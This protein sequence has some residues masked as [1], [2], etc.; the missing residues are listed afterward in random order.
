MGLR[1]N[2][3]LQKIRELEGSFEFAES[4]V[5]IRRDKPLGEK[6]DFAIHNSWYEASKLFECTYKR[7]CS[8]QTRY[9]AGRKYCQK[10]LD[11]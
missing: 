8:Y 11:R 3:Y 6:C 9:G 4:P 5:L 7:E 1:M 10:E 2:E